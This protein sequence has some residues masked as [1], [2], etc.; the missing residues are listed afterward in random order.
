MLVVFHGTL[1]FDDDVDIYGFIETTGIQYWINTQFLRNGD[2]AVFTNWL[3]TYFNIIS[4]LN[5]SAPPVVLWPSNLAGT[6][7][8]KDSLK[9]RLI[10]TLWMFPGCYEKRPVVESLKSLNPASLS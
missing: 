9:G 8:F 10:G 5:D 7:Y 3:E 1:F 6:E 2:Y 4:V